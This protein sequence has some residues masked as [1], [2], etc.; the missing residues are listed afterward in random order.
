V[1]EVAQLVF[2]ELIIWFSGDKERIPYVSIK[3]IELV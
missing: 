1:L 2:P 3:S